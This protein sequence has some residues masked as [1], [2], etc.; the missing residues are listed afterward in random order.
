MA[1]SAVSLKI[2]GKRPVF[3]TN[4]SVSPGRSRPRGVL[5][6]IVFIQEFL[7]NGSQARRQLHGME[8]HKG[9]LLQHYGTVDRVKGVRSPGEGA[10]TMD[11]HRRNLRQVQLPLPEGLNNDIP[12]LLLIAPGDFLR[13]HF[14]GAGNLAVEVVPLGGPLGGNPFPRLG[15]GGGP[16]AVRVDNASQRWKPLYSARCVSVSLE[17]L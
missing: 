4:P 11:Q 16:A 14:P 17:G 5:A 10:V 3:R 2:P 1:H 12:R 7:L 15:K 6:K 9:V 13:R 8:I